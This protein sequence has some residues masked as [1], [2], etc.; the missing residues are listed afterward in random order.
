M[1]S[2]NTRTTHEEGVPGRVILAGVTG[3]TAYG[4]TT[5][6]SDVDT[7]GVY[8]AP[9]REILGIHGGRAADRTITRTEPDSAF[10]E[11]G[12]YVRLALKANPTVLELLYLEGH[13]A[14]TGE[15]SALIT[16]RDM[17]LG[18]ETI[19]SAHGGYA[20]NQAKFL[21]HR[22][23]R[24]E[25]GSGSV[26]A[27]RTEK[28]ARHCLRLLLQGTQLLQDGMMAVNVGDQRDTLFA[29]A[30]SRWRTPKRSRNSR[31]RR[32]RNWKKLSPRAGYL[33]APTKNERT[34]S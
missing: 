8:A 19:R 34:V 33:P 14:L 15:G 28:H 2:D 5:P 10:H 25:E 4:L 7:L 11:V 32:C 21:A 22:H 31:G 6:T 17:F 18:K 12:K 9:T 3:S 26:P 24:G 20:M 13:T 16:G 1:R 23:T 30:G 27:N 29:G